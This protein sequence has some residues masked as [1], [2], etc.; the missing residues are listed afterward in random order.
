MLKKLYFDIP[1]NL[2]VVQND[3]MFTFDF[4]KERLELFVVQ[5]SWSNKV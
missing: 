2:R 1:M 5:P 3:S 4:V